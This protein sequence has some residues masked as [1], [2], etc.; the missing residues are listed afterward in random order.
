LA[1]LF[2]GHDV[3]LNRRSWPVTLLFACSVSSHSASI[4]SE[5]HAFIAQFWNTKIVTCSGYIVW[6]TAD[7]SGFVEAEAKKNS[8]QWIVKSFEITRTNE[9]N[10]LQ[11]HGSTNLNVARARTWSKGWGEWGDYGVYSHDFGLLAIYTEFFV[12]K[13]QG[14][15]FQIVNGENLQL[16]SCR[17]L[18]GENAPTVTKPV[19]PQLPPTPPPPRSVEGS[20]LLYSYTGGSLSPP[21]PG[22][23]KLLGSITVAQQPDGVIVVSGE[24]FPSPNEFIRAH[25]RPGY[26]APFT[27]HRGHPS[28]AYLQVLKDGKLWFLLADGGFY[29]AAPEPK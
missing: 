13:K 11:W 8:P 19:A 17:E 23:T 27:D 2:G 18:P 12:S 24:H 26:E 1:S 10:G 25:S 5:A 22:N 4:D 15:P 28:K 9:L 20:Y 14:K 3:M 21:G 7:G 16:A 6:K 29:I